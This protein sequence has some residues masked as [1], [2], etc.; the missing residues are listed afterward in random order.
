MRRWIRRK[1]LAVVLPGVMAEHTGPISWE[2][3]AWSAVLWAEPAALAMASAVRAA[4]GSASTFPGASAD[5]RQ[6]HLAIARG[7]HLRAPT[8]IRLHSR[9]SL[10]RSVLWVASPPR[11][12]EEEA[13]LDLALAYLS[14]G[15]RHAHLN[16]VAAIAEPI[17]AGRTTAARVLESLDRRSRVAHREWLVGVVEDVGAGATS[18]LEQGYVRRV[19]RPHGLPPGSLQV[20]QALL[21][22]S[23]IRDGLVLGR[24]II[25][26]DGRA[27]HQGAGRR[28]SDLERDLD[29]AAVGLGRVV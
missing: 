27:F 6:I 7:R 5:E 21:S 20:A 15:R 10:E 25:E 8:W 16:A 18:V 24:Q 28:D 2:Q 17:Q 23:V 3:R 22:G 13:A 9:A 29:A 12:R 19:Q 11:Q 14:R 4:R 26:L 1:D